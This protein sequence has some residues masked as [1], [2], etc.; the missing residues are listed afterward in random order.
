MRYNNTLDFYSSYYEPEPFSS[1]NSINGEYFGGPSIRN[2]NVKG[3]PSLHS[4]N[5]AFLFT[6]EIL[7]PE[8]SSTTTTISSW[9]SGWQQDVIPNGYTD[10]GVDNFRFTDTVSS[11]NTPKAYAQSQD[12]PVGICYLDKGFIVL[13]DPT[14]VQ[15]FLYSGSASG[16][17][18]T[19]ID[20]GYTGVESGF[21]QVF[22]TADTSGSCTY[23]SFEREILLT[24]NVVANSGEFFITE[25]QTASSADAPYYG[26]GGSD[27]GIQFMT[28]FGEV[29]QV[30][31]LSSV[32]ST[33]ITEIGLYDAQNRL[34]AIA[35]PDRPIK[36]P[37]NTPVT[38][39]LKLKF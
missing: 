13:T 24:I 33:Y 32:S 1:D 19:T 9:S 12:I 25:N 6:D 17:S 11:S 29:N 39:T 28:P 7:G 8:M 26:A 34:L 22:F 20:Y 4:T 10:G 21:T 35:K 3:N 36:K 14:I 2:E 18:A 23:Y 15:N 27:T 31:D 37:K 30:W 38:L 16:T 5:I